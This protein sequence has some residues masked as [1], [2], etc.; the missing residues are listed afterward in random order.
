[1]AIMIG[2]DEAGYGPILGPLVVS[3]AVFQ[4]P[5]ALVSAPLWEVLPQSVC[6]R[7]GGS[8]GR[9][10]VNDSKK[11]HKGRGDY[12]A[13]QRGVLACLAAGGG[14]V[15][16][17]LGELL[18]T[19]EVDCREELGQYPWYG[20]AA[21]REL[22]FDRDDI[23]TAAAA[24][25]QE[26][27]SKGVRLQGLWSRILPAG[28]FNRMVAA[29]DNKASVLF[30]L[31]S[32]LIYLGYR[33][34]GQNGLQILTDKQGGRM[35]YRKQLQR[36]F[37]HHQMKIIKESEAVS[38]YH[39]TEP[40]RPG[41]GMKTHFLAKGETRQ[42]PIALASMTSK[43][44][45]EL[46]MESLNGF[47]GRHCPGIKPTAGYYRDGKRFLADLATYDLPGHLVEDELLVRQ[48]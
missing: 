15:P 28:R 33:R 20:A 27:E 22:S 17:S 8:A 21:E 5:D 9:I 18:D 31:A 43:Y 16:T 42:L 41:A 32:E 48:R 1:M 10:A 11:L 34:F 7:V 30:T 13:L 44:V 38:S 37:P 12:A 6:R 23:G 19:L 35:R 2:I 29:V 24:L 46:L 47:F 14:G 26:M 36:L 39:L 45:R 40:D 3:G 4:V 25:G